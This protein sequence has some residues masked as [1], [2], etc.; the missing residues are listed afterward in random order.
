MRRPCPTGARGKCKADL[1][2]LGWMT[3]LEVGDEILKVMQL[4]QVLLTLSQHGQG[5]PHED[6]RAVLCQHDVNHPAGEGGREGVAVD[7]EE[8]LGG[9]QHWH[10]SVVLQHTPVG[11]AVMALSP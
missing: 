6:V 2:S 7:G 4:E 3:C 11:T 5:C 9:I 1:Q 10:S 8:P